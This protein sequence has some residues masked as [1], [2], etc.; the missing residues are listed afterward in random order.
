MYIPK[1]YKEND[2]KKL[3]GFMREYNFAAIINSTKKRYWATHLPFLIFE[4]NDDVI[5]K[6]HMAKSNPQWVNFGKEEVL[7]IFQEPHA[8]ISPKL[9]DHYVNVPTWNYIAIHAY[10]VPEILS[11]REQRINILEESFKA[12]DKDYKD[13]WDKLPADYKN[14][15]LEGIVAF[16]IKI[17]KLEGKFKLSQNRTK[18]ERKKIISHLSQSNEKT[19][20]QIAKTMENM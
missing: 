12:F 9:Y 18:D 19:N 4:E 3:V 15:M 16:R 20:V 8:Y 11:G 13:Q 17:N 10:G 1:H 5:L 2:R 7:V 6:A 14:E